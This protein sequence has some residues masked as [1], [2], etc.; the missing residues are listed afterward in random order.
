MLLEPGKFY[1]SRAGETWCCYRVNP[2]APV[3]AVADCI[4]VNDGRTEYF[5]ADGRYDGD[6]IREHCLVAVTES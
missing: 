2:N 3:Q 5:Y 4:R 6:G 1:R